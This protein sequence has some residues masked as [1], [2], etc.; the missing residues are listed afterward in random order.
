LILLLL[1]LQL[2]RE[3]PFTLRISFTAATVS[4]YCYFGRVF[5]SS[6][7]SSIGLLL[8][9]LCILVCVRSKSINRKRPSPARR[10]VW[11]VLS[12]NNYDYQLCTVAITRLCFVLDVDFDFP[13]R[14]TW[15]GW[16]SSDNSR[17]R[18]RTKRASPHAHVFLLRTCNTPNL[19]SAVL[20]SS[21]IIQL[22]IDLV[23][24]YLKVRTLS[25]ISRGCFTI[26]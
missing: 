2:Q 5:R 15:L 19:C 12:F 11:F 13:H 16:Y 6:G 17:D 9:P 26:F 10:T 3:Y 8:R 23:S 20:V 7:T 18:G 22:N 14:S 21:L 24:N 25:V 4:G 1:L